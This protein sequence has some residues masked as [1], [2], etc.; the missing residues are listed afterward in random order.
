MS[1]PIL[2]QGMT[3]NHTRGYVPMVAT[4]QRFQELHPE[5]TISWAKRSL[6]EFADAPLSDL[7]EK[8]DFLVIDHPWAGFAST[9]GILLPLEKHL[10]DDFLA[11][12]AANSVGQSHTSYNFGG[13][14]WALAIDA[15][16]PVS[17][18][19]PDLL[20][21]AGVGLPRTFDDLIA[22]GKRG[23]VCCPSI[24]LDVYGNLLNL[25]V[26][27]GETIFPNP[28][29]IAERDAALIA[30]DRLKQLA[31][32]VPARFFD[33]NPIRTMEVMSQ[34][35]SFAYAPYTYG[36]TN[37]SRPGYAPHLVKFGDVIGIQ[38]DQPGATMLG[39]TGLTISAR[40][41]HPDIAAQY[42]QFV[43]SGPTQRGIFFH[44]GGQPGHRSAW[45]DSSIN[46]ACSDFFHDTLPTLDRAFVRP[47]YSGYLDFQDHAGL[48]IHEFLRNG[49]D[50]GRVLEKVNS[51]Y[52]E[53]HQS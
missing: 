11:D 8:F 36:Y 38:A 35:N 4:S 46:A 41:K 31:D 28:E 43:A 25:L 7:A 5:V 32:V 42:A 9:S 33:L 10:P 26:A 17:A 40:C 34:E 39:G 50:P 48:P 47:R 20:E 49:G 3:W 6:Q 1:E 16:C 29:E 13:S 27:A 52:R 22:L 53:S 14:Q 51:M 21:K 18:S 2:L 12:Q 15:A 45:L 44:S 24:P 37:Y 30:L 23:L 19:R